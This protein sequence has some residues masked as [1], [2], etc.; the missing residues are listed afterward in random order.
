LGPSV[1]PATTGVPPGSLES[2]VAAPLPRVA[3]PPVDEIDWRK[4]EVDRF[5]RDAEEAVR[6]NDLEAARMYYWGAL[7]FNPANLVARMRLGLVLKQQGQNQR[8]L[9]E[10]I[11][12]TKLV[13]DYAEA[14]KEKGIAE[15][16]I[17]RNIPADKRP[18]WLADGSESLRRA[19]LLNPA[20]FDAW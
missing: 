10:F 13:P 11:T 18:K 19:T 17:A 20:D 15:G 7:R 3:H 9:E 2:S 16:L 5:L 1:S 4:L 12:V 6:M 8:A 14:W